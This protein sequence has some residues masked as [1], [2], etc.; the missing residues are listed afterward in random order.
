MTNKTRRA[1]PGALSRGKAISVKTQTKNKKQIKSREAYEITMNEIDTLMKRGESN[2]SKKELDRLRILAEAAELYEDTH[3]PLPV[4]TTIP[5]MIRMR[6][7]QMQ[8]NQGFA[9]KLLGVSDAKFSMIMTGKQR[10]D[11]YFIKAIH[12]KLKVDANLILK[13]L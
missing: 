8:L 12:D 1:N 2:L 6:M 9:A 5:E 10:P 13:A 4:P 3:E 11:V 7:Y